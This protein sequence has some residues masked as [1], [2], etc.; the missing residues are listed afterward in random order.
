MV[1]VGI[2]KIRKR[3]K[4]LCTNCDE[5]KIGKEAESCSNSSH[6]AVGSEVKISRQVEDAVIVMEVEIN[7]EADESFN[8]TILN[9]APNQLNEL[10]I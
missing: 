6:G 3:E 8:N 10:K 1:C 5:E 7:D 9:P 2:T 4:Y